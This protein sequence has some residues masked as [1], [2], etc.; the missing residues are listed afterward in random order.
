MI[1]DI[2]FAFIIL[3]LYTF[4]VYFRSIKMNNIGIIGTGIWGTALGLTSARA[5]NNVLFW[6]RRQQVIDD[7]NASHTNSE[8]FPDITLPDSISA[9]TD[10]SRVFDFSETILLCVSS[11]NKREVLKNIHPFI[12]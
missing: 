12:K 7:I 4:C 9:T 11:Q 6:G 2:L 8:H 5:G 3:F 1:T 10:L